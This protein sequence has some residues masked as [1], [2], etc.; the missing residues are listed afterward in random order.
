MLVEKSTAVGVDAL[1]P[2]DEWWVVGGR[3]RTRFSPD[4]RGSR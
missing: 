4:P 1:Q 2:S 3:A